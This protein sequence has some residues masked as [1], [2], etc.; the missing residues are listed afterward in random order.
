MQG[1]RGI[2]FMDDVT[3]VAEGRNTN[4]VVQCIERCATASL[5]WVEDDAVRFETSKTEAMLF[6]RKRKHWQPKAEK[7]IRVG[8]QTVFFARDPTRWLGIR[9]GSASTYGRTDD[10][11]STERERPRPGSGG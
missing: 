9:L 11:A 3:W 10:G 7:P 2:S 6:S 1:C 8:D 4:E 5:R